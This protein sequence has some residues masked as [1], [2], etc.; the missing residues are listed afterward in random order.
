MITIKISNERERN[1]IP[2]LQ[3]GGLTEMAQCQ[4]ESSSSDLAR[5]E[6]S[7][8]GRAEAGARSDELREKYF[9]LPPDKRPNYNILGAL[10]PF[11]RPWGQLLGDQGWFVLRDQEVIKDLQSRRPRS[12]YEH[13]DRALVVVHIRMEGKGSLTENTG[14]YSPL[15]CDLTGG[16]LVLTEIK[17][18]DENCAARKESRL[19]HQEKL[20]RLKRQWKKIK[21]KKTQMVLTSAMEDN[22]LDQN[23]MSE[24]ELSL[25]SLKGLREEEKHGYKDSSEASWLTQDLSKIR[26]HNSRRLIGWVVNGGYSLRAGAEVGVCLMALS[27]LNILVQDN[28]TRVLTRQ[29]DNHVYRFAFFEVS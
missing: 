11:S 22:T 9:R 26:D 17:H 16:E 18:K 19:K 8:W 5:M 10:S 28:V 3:V 14:L 12:D 2:T 1:D 7:A 25:K 20:K 6:D 24:I 23:K 27:D 13:A 4:L 29:P 21:T 15:E